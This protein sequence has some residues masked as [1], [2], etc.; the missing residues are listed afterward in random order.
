MKKSESEVIDG[1]KDFQGRLADAQTRQDYWVETVIMEFTE[2]MLARMEER[3]ISKSELASKMGV[4]PAAISKFL[5][6]G[7]NFTIETMVKVAQALN[8]QVR[9]N[10]QPEGV[11]SEWLN[12]LKKKPIQQPQPEPAPSDYQDTGLTQK[13]DLYESFTAAA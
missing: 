13:M 11:A 10:L 12:F 9:V 1:T 4:K 8:C 5:G 3:G 7:N 2:A 6:G